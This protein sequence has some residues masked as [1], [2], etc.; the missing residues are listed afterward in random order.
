MVDIPKFRRLSTV[1]GELRT[2]DENLFCSLVPLIA[3]LY[4]GVE[5]FDDVFG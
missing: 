3:R 5:E 1:E 2:R 4:V